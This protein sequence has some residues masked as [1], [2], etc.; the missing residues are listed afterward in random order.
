MCISLLQQNSTAFT[1]YGYFSEG[2][3]LVGMA[4]DY[5]S[6]CLPAIVGGSRVESI[7]V[8]AFTR[9]FVL[10]AVGSG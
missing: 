5:F 2:G 6:S 7:P 3:V 4:S 10:M 9:T 1:I 8:R